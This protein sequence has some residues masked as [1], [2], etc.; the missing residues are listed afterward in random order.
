MHRVMRVVR[1][2][3][4]AGGTDSVLLAPR[5]RQVQRG[6]LITRQGLRLALDLPEPVL[7]R[8]GDAL[9]LDDGRRIEVVAEPE[10]LLEVRAADLVALARIAWALGDRHV[11]V[12]VL[13]N[14]LRLRPDSALERMLVRLGA[15]IA[16]IEAP[17]DP[18]GG[19][20]AAHVHAG[21]AHGDHCAHHEH[22]GHHHHGLGHRH[23]R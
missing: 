22:E 12:Q 15:R 23:E 18:E 16:P 11:P 6:E 1:A 8:M 21:H 7:L 14:R 4:G 10:P 9:E 3:A 20:Y 2:G 19:A 13:P 5:E 17:F